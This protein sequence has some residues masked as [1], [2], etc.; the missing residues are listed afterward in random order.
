MSQLIFLK[1]EVGLCRGAPPCWQSHLLDMAS[2]VHV[3]K[4]VSC[5]S[6]KNSSPVLPQYILTLITS[7]RA[8]SKYSYLWG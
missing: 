5:L 7:I 1:L 6:H 8:I 3:Q 2:L 4:D